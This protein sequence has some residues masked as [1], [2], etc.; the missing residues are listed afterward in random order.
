MGMGLAVHM[1]PGGLWVGTQAMDVWEKGRGGGGDGTLGLGS[2]DPALGAEPGWA[3]P[4]T[5]STR[6]GLPALRSLQPPHS[7]FPAGPVALAP[8][9]LP[10]PPPGPQ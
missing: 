1:G 7:A 8:L 6:V 9:H 3:A 2:K 5:S 10:G 4:A